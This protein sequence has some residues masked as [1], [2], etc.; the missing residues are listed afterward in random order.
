MNRQIIRLPDNILRQEVVVRALRLT[1]RNLPV[2]EVA[3]V[4]LRQEVVHRV[5]ALTATL[6]PVAAV[7]V[8]VVAV[9]AVVAVVQVAVVGNNL[10]VK[11]KW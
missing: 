1:L 5:V 7:Q 9:V 6:H 3:K 2:Q 11:R 10:V 8:V 4:I